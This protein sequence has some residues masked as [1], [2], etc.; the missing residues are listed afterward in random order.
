MKKIVL[1]LLLVSSLACGLLENVTSVVPVPN[2]PPSSSLSALK[3]VETSTLR[4]KART[5]LTLCEV[6][7][8]V[9]NGGL[10]NLREGPGANYT[11]VRVL[12]EGEVIVLANL[13]A[14]NGWQSVI[15]ES[16]E[17]WVN[18]TYIKCEVTQ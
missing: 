12:H 18:A 6:S 8:G 13:P 4:T 14:Q 15:A 17:G 2:Q 3:K 1:L 10:L 9:E 7:T 11:P 16:V 5:S